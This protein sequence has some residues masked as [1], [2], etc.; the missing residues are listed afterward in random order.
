[1]S[2]QGHNEEG[3]A[4]I[5]QGIAAHQ[6]TGAKTSQSWYFGLLAEAYGKVGRVEQG[7]DVLKESLA[8]LQR[9]GERFYEAELYRLTGE[10]PLMQ[11][12]SNIIETERWFRASIEIAQHQQAKSFERATTS[13]ARLLA[14]RGH[15][16]EALAMLVEI[17]NW[18]IEGSDTA[19]LQDAK[20]LL[21]Q[22]QAL[23]G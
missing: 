17:Y 21:D 22:L 23:G 14:K 7:L 20:A 8:I 9:T 16:D 6:A 2:E 5:L 10:L 15:R 19:D 4:Q 12:A 13:L 11:R 1:L 3:I 18:F